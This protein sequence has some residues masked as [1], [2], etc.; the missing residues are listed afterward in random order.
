MKYLMQIA[1]ILIILALTSAV[2]AQVSVS[3]RVADEIYVGEAFQMDVSAENGK[4]APQVDAGE[5]AG[6]NPNFLN[7]S[8]G[9]SSSTIII[10][11][12]VVQDKSEFVSSWSLKVDKAGD[13]TIPALTVTVD[14]RQ[15]KTQPVSFKAISPESSDLVGLEAKLSTDECY[16]GQPVAMA[17]KWYVPGRAMAG[18]DFDIPALVDTSMFHTGNLEAPQNG[19][20][21]QQVEN[22]ELG[23]M[24]AS[25]TVGEYKGRQTNII[26]FNKYI[27]P[28]K[29]GELVI[30][31]ISVICKLQTGT[32]SS[33]SNSP[34]DDPF[35]QMRQPTYSRFQASAQPLKLNVKPLPQD[36]K[37]AGFYGLVATKMFIRAE[38]VSPP[39]EI[40]VGTPLT[41]KITIYG[42]GNLLEGVKMPDLSFLTG[43]FKLPPDQASPERTEEGLVFTQTVRPMRSSEEG[44]VEMPSITLPYF[45]YQAKE[46]QVAKTEPIAIKVQGARIIEQADATTAVND[47]PVG[48]ELTRARPQIAANHYGDEVLVG[49]AFSLRDE[50]LNV[51]SLAAISCP[52]VL[53][54]VSLYI[55]LA[56]V[57]DPAKMQARIASAALSR[58]VK[59]AGGLPDTSNEKYSAMLT[60]ILRGYIADKFSLTA[61][62]LTAD[63]CREKLVATG[64]SAANVERFCGIVEYG[65]HSRYAGSFKLTVVVP[66]K[67]EVIALL[68][69]VDGEVKGAKC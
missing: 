14:G 49:R 35:F 20:Q 59:L 38:L 56:G 30:D 64:V 27:I 69:A 29:T 5:L 63:D 42:N 23:N 37:P 13:Y 61:Q 41:L 31:P 21:V 32:T 2:G 9:S 57:K 6:F 11:G 46:Y 45:N 52:S 17:V 58:A 48:S 60:E 18:Y 65:E 28:Q 33:R 24:E 34:F 22:K 43:D 66:D 55:S 7:S 47:Q 8:V 40:S 12:R 62:S 53:V 68:R 51:W 50:L 15:Y 54:L 19:G 1:V 67:K 39:A 10:N 4:S 36:G 3:V 25:V 26:E 16:L 44:L